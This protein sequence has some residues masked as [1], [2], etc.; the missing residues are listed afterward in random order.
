MRSSGAWGVFDNDDGETESLD[1]HFLPPQPHGS[2]ESQSPLPP[3]GKNPSLR[4]LR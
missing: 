3:D 4:D 2:L 1:N